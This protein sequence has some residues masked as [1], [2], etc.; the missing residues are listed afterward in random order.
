MGREK[1]QDLNILHVEFLHI[2]LIIKYHVSI[3][4]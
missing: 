4:S 1:D 3:D 2:F